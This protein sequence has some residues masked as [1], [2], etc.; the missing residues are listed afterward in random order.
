MV[1]EPMKAAAKRS[2]G[3]SNSAAGGPAWTIFPLCINTTRS[4][5]DMASRW[6]WV[7]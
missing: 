6:S 4:A 3:L 1:G 2:T 7:T 5:S